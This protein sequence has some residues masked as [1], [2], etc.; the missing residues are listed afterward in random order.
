M[1]RM[2]VQIQMR[3]LLMLMLMKRMILK[4]FWHLHPDLDSTFQIV[5][6]CRLCL[7]LHSYCDDDMYLCV[8]NRGVFPYVFD[9]NCVCIIF[10]NSDSAFLPR[11][12]LFCC[13]Y[14]FF[15]FAFFFY[16]MVCL[17]RVESVLYC[18]VLYCIVLYCIVYC[19]TQKSLFETT[20]GICT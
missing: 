9:A 8:V 10:I 13:V 11:S 5:V 14:F 2:Q 7:T 12:L 6:A 19:N 4:H 18:I 15:S 16:S 17:R 1:G 20:D 3:K